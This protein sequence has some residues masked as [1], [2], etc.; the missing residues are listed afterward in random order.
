MQI[1]YGLPAG[2]ADGLAIEDPDDE[3]AR[4]EADCAEAVGGG[5]LLLWEETE[6]AERSESAALLD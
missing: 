4:M 5:L 1:A 2:T 6:L 3:I